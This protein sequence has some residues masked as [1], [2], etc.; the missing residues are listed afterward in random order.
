MPL[1][2]WEAMLELSK[3]DELLH[4]LGLAQE[5]AMKMAA[6]REKQTSLMNGRSHP[7]R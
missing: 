1:F 5:D 3:V 2:T 7:E 4:A 6:A